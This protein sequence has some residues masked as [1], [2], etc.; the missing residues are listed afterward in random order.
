MPD[1]FSGVATLMVMGF[2]AV[3]GVGAVGIMTEALNDNP[4]STATKKAIDVIARTG[5]AAA[6]AISGMLMV[7]PFFMPLP[8]LVGISAFLL[9]T[10]TVTA[11]INHN[12]GTPIK[13]LVIVD[14]T[15]DVIVKIINVAAIFLGGGL[16]YDVPTKYAPIALAAL[17]T[18]S[19]MNM[20]NLYKKYL[21]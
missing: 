1:S 11:V 10:P 16:I 2:Y 18:L 14:R 7:G 19:T 9:L 20:Y 8:A 6:A 15:A 12:R 13:A 5:Q 21:K 4:E 17:S 3:Q